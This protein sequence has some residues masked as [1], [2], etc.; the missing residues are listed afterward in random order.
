MLTDT[1][2]GQCVCPGID[3]TCE[4][5]I[6]DENTIGAATVWTGT[7]FDCPETENEITLPHIPSRFTSTT[8]LGC[9]DGAIRGRGIRIEENRYI[10]QVN[11][12]VDS[13]M[14]G[15]TVECY[16]ESGIQLKTLISNF[17]IVFTSG[18]T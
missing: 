9:N 13:Y 18:T 17:S 6:K 7:A 14:D 12:N 5:T 10:S 11:I 4:C 8:S 2:S 15:K 3:L 16:H 1:L